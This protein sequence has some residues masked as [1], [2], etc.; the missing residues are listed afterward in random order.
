MTSPLSSN[1]PLGRACARNSTNKICWVPCSTSTQKKL[2]K[3]W[4]A[5][6][7][8]LAEQFASTHCDTPADHTAHPSSANCSYWQSDLTRSLLPDLYKSESRNQHLAFRANSGSG[9]RYCYKGVFLLKARF[10]VLH[11][12]LLSCLSLGLCYN[13]NTKLCIG[14]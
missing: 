7:Q 12:V 2:D 6:Q 3:L 14:M 5:K 4:Y 10:W 1:I 8:H 13:K 11:V 9:T